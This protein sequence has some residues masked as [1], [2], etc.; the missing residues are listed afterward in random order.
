MNGDDLVKLIHP[1]V[2][3]PLAMPSDDDTPPRL[4][5]SPE[6]TDEVFVITVHGPYDISTPGSIANLAED[7]G[8]AIPRR[9]T[10]VDAGGEKFRGSLGRAMGMGGAAEVQRPERRATEHHPVWSMCIP[11]HQFKEESPEADPA[12]GD[13]GTSG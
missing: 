2:P 6:G 10:V 12:R 4:L 1:H 5:A 13:L 3:Q 9:A 7:L 11:C 8:I